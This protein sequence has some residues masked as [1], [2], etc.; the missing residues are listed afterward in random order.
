MLIT[1]DLLKSW[2]ATC[3]L[4][5][6]PK[7][8]IE[9]TRENALKAPPGKYA[10]LWFLREM[11]ARVDGKDGDLALALLQEEVGS[12]DVSWLA[13]AIVRAKGRDTKAAVDKVLD[14]GDAHSLSVLVRNGDAAVAERAAPVLVEKASALM[15]DECIKQFPSDR[16]SLLEARKAVRHGL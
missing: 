12:D 6:M 1:A 7:G 9:F 8:G 10:R 13:T 2:G 15:V 4:D 14:T 5:W 11:A 3:S 16:A